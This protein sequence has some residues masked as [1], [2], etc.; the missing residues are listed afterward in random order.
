[1]KTTV[2]PVLRLQFTLVV[3]TEGKTLCNLARPIGRNQTKARIALV[4][5]GVGIGQDQPTVRGTANN[6]NHANH[7]RACMTRAPDLRRCRCNLR[8]RH[9]RYLQFPLLA[10]MRYPTRHD[11]C[12]RRFRR[13]S[14]L[15]AMHRKM[16]AGCGDLPG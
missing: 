16:T 11:L 9:L 3:G 13:D 8:L 2:F 6:A 12:G 10:S 7:A 5:L 4:S 15:R 1:M 14:S